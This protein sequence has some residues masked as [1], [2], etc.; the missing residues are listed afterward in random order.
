MRKSS[1]AAAL[2]AGALA[3]AVAACGSDDTPS[4]SGGGGDATATATEAAKAKVGVILPDAASSARWETADRKFLVR[5][6]R[7][8]GWSRIFRTRNGDKAKFA[9]IADQ[10][11]NGGANVLLIVNLDTRRRRR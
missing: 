9:T 2:A 6:L 3:F 5:P 1:L 4:T 10:M 7:P 11:L 8:P